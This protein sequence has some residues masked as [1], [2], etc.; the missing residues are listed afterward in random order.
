MTPDCRIVPI[1]DSS[2]AVEFDERID[3]SVNAR[4]IRVAELVQA[5]RFPGVRDVV[6]TYCSVAVYFDPL[7]TTVDRLIARLEGVVAS[8]KDARPRDG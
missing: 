8:V 4:A 2:V 7:R 6:P 5:D 1:G 3:A